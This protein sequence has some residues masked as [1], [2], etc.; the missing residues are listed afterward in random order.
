MM[1]DRMCLLC[2]QGAYQSWCAPVQRRSDERYQTGVTASPSPAD[3]CAD[4]E[5][6]KFAQSSMP[7][8]E[9]MQRVLRWYKN[10]QKCSCY[11][12]GHRRKRCGLTVQER[13]QSYAEEFEMGDEMH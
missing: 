1:I 3:D 13:R 2:T 11:M 9:R 8:E 10:R 4:D 7:E 5:N 6:E 12:C